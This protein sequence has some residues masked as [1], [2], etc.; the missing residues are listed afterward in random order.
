MRTL[1][2]RAASLAVILTF[3]PAALAQWNPSAGQWGKQAPEH[4]RVISWNVADGICSTNN[5]SEGQ[6]NWCAI[7]RTIAAFQPDVLIL[8]EC[9]DNNGN[10]TGSSSDSVS[11][12][13]TTMGLLINGGN[14]PFQGGSVGSYVRKYAP[15]YQLPYI[16]VSSDGD[17]YNRNVIASR[18]PFTDLNGD[19]RST[20]SNIPSVSNTAYAPGGDGGIRG[21]MF[22]EID[23]PDATYPDDLVVGN[24]H[25]K[26][27]GGSSNES[28]RR[29]AAQNVAYYIDYLYN[30][31]GTG[32]PDPNG[33]I[34]DS[35]QATSI[36]PPGTPVVI[37]GDW[38][39]DE[40]TNGQKG[41]ADWLTRA[42]FTGGSDGTDRNGSDM[43]IDAATRF[44]TGSD[45]TLGNV[46][47]DY[48]A[49][50]DSIVSPSAV[51]TVW[52]SGST[53]S[54]LMPSQVQG[55]P[56]PSSITSVASDHNPVIVDF[57]IDT[58]S[59]GCTAPTNY[60]SSTPN[61]V[62]VGTQI[63]Y[64]GSNSVV[65]NDFN[66]IS[67]ASP[68]NTFGLF[69]HGGGQTSVPLGDGVRCVGAG[70]VGLFRFNPAELTSIFGEAFRPVD[71]AN[72]SQPAAQITAG[73]TWYFQ[74]WY[75]DASG[76]PAGFNLSDGLAVTFCP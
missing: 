50:Q 24:A 4:I 12:L 13:T 61:S 59:G 68:S 33:K 52:D 70:G 44:F 35:P 55:F 16:F 6:N 21:F 25:L 28:Q 39:E 32:S 49:Y 57:D 22:A 2:T 46:K 54:G 58:A 40:V 11:T 9:G 36:L 60:C 23:L 43:T 71:I 15:S 63:T 38:N 66:L 27:G 62:G 3:S 51:Q 37:G 42:E 31:A 74:Y 20:I 75:R 14:D 56:N 65:S 34:S 45:N 7:A 73:S 53:P 18:F 67:S 76:G 19:T 17:N 41:P 69:F 48:L 8:Q 64:L 72:P 30:G 10:G 26:A 29:K 47:F 5:K 1:L